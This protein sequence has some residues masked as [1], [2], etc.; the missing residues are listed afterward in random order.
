M[1]V[2]DAFNPLFSL[3]AHGC[4]RSETVARIIRHLDFKGKGRIVERIRTDSMNREVSAMCGGVKF[5]LD[6]HDDMQREIY[7]NVFAR[8][9]LRQ[10][11]K[12]IPVG[13]TCLDIGANNGAFAL[14][15][16]RKVGETGLVHA[17][18][19]DP[20][21]YPRLLVNS[22]LNS[23]EN[24]LKCHQLAVSNVN[25]P[26]PFYESGRH[27]TGWGSLE[28]FKD[29][30][31]QTATV[32][33]ITLD[34]FLARERIQ[35]VDFLKVDIEAYEPELLEGAR[36]SL[37]NRVFRYMLIEFN[38][39]R[40][41]ERGKSLEDFLEPILGNGYGAIHFTAPGLDRLRNRTVA[42]ETVC[43][44]FLFAPLT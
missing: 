6:L 16:A 31:E 5:R 30:A 20:Y 38:G 42:A 17:F 22:Q 28:K 21:V 11:L 25:G 29:I 14:Q 44:S 15:F 8:S 12:L 37:R 24:V 36:D 27:H 10:A 23:F 32:Q 19:P 35:R 33:S 39:I 43:T 2:K 18:E 34:D 41:A 13:G 40:L 26:L 4:S 1:S 9:E 7:F 3:A